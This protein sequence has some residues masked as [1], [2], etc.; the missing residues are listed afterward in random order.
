MYIGWCDWVQVHDGN[1]AR[2]MCHMLR[3][4]MPAVQTESLDVP[5]AQ[6][7]GPQMEARQYN[8]NIDKK[9]SHRLAMEAM[10]STGE[11]FYIPMQDFQPVDWEGLDLP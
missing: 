2:A 8:H 7:T 5:W 1:A 10:D 4:E 3:A 9:I 11:A 6:I